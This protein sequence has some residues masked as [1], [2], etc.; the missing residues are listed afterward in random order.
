MCLECALLQYKTEKDGIVEIHVEH[1]VTIHSGANIDHDA[2]S[3]FGLFIEW[4]F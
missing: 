3:Y 2:V 1:R 4:H